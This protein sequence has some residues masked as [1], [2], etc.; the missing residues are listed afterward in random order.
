MADTVGLLLA[1]GAGRRYGSPKILVDDW[2]ER[3]VGAL[4]GGGCDT[5]AVVTGAARPPLPDGV[6]EVHCPDWHRGMGASLRAGLRA[7]RALRPRRVVVHVVDAPDVSAAVV[8]R[9]LAVPGDL[10]VRA[11]F[12]ARPGHPVVL[13][14]AVLD[15]VAALLAGDA[16]DL[17][18]GARPWFAA[19]PHRLVDCADLATGLDIDRRQPC[20]T[21]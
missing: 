21:S 16:H 4:A 3:A 18:L 10:A 8:A 20:V 13:P 5:V 2:L 15:G 12:G 7:V 19:H 11:T 6:L 14:S 9:V 17:E 1:A